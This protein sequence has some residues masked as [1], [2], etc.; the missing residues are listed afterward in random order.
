MATSA[1]AGNSPFTLVTGQVAVGSK[2]EFSPQV[3]AARLTAAGGFAVGGYTPTVAI[4]AGA[5]TVGSISGVTGY[6]QAASFTLVAG[7]ANIQAGTLA[8][9]TF[10]QPLTT[11]P[12]AAIVNMYN[13]SGTL[14]IAVGAFG[15]SKTGFS[16]GGA[17]PVSGGTYS[18]NWFVVRSPL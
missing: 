12:I 8:T 10:G 11:A 6:D 9:V 13:P 3:N 16:I 7:T 15:L 4:G 2:A 14:G 18:V 17:V 1:G 5:G